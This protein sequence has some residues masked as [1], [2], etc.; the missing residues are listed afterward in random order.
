MYELTFSTDPRQI[1]F[2][3]ANS[4]FTYAWTNVDER[5]PSNITQFHDGHLRL[6]GDQFIDLNAP[7]EGDP[8]SVGAAPLPLIGGVSGGDGTLPGGFTIEVLFKALTVERGAKVLDFGNGPGRDNIILGYETNSNRLS[9]EQYVEGVYWSMPCINSVTL[10]A[11]YHVVITFHRARWNRIDER[12]N[13]TC[14]VN[15]AQSFTRP[16]VPMPLAVRRST[17]FIGRSHWVGDEYFDLLLDTF[18]LFDYALLPQEVRELYTVTHEPLPVDV[19]PA[20]DHR[21][22][23]GPLASY[24]F[25]QPTTALQRSLGTYYNH[26][27]GSFLPTQFPHIG[28]AHFTG[29]SGDGVNLNTYEADEGGD[30]PIIGGG[31]VSVEVWVRFDAWSNYNRVW[32]LGGNLGYQDNNLVLTTLGATDTLMFV[33]F[34]GTSAS[35]SSCPTPSCAA[36]GSTSSAWPSSATSATPPARPARCCACTSTASWWA[37]CS[38]TS[39]SASHGRRLSSDGPTGSPTRRCRAPST[40][41]TCTIARSTTRRSAPT[42][43][44]TSRPCSSWPSRATR[45][46]GSASTATTP[47]SRTAG[48][49]STPQT[50]PPTPRCTTTAT[51]C[52]QATAGSTCRRPPALSPSAPPSRWSCSAAARRPREGRG[53]RRSWGGASS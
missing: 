44:P 47:S 5:D 33:S 46:P 35:A 2:G 8:S 27:R 41:S 40:P 11:W 16:N 25:L 51:S 34:L 15:G 43:S 22:H 37:P 20:V 32:D 39:L 38:A 6:T 52:S 29:A 7:S 48:R 28:L 19:N 1:F 3:R 26:T 42:T 17:S 21:Y 53:V 14:F 36:G 4:F 31:S 49:R 10:N 23:S 50:R 45:C 9:L 13:V 12:G 30:L 18:R 24:K